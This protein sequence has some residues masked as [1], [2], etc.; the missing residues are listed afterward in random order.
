MALK[1]K[2]NNPFAFR[3]V[4]PELEKATEDVTVLLKLFQ[5]R[6]NDLK[7]K[8]GRFCINKPKSEYIISQY[9]DFFNVSD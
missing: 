9:E 8:Y 3:C 6:K 7:E 4:L 2:F 1:K 5:K